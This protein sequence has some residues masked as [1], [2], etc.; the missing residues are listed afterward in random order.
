MWPTCSSSSS[1]SKP[2]FV[3]YLLSL[4][5]PFDFIIHAK[6]SAPP[7][8]CPAPPA[9]YVPPWHMPAATHS[10]WRLMQWQAQ[11]LSCYSW[12]RVNSH[13]VIVC[14][15]SCM[16]WQCGKRNRPVNASFGFTTTSGRRVKHQ[17]GAKPNG[18]KKHERHV[19]H[20]LPVSTMRSFP[21]DIMTETTVSRLHKA[22]RIRTLWFACTSF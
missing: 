7:L 9:E 10:R 16:Q 21:R 19:A 12:A 20:V 8:P 15:R 11:Y 13:C 14:S 3:H 18:G 17:S 1:I 22:K 5:P 4:I 6:W 2:V